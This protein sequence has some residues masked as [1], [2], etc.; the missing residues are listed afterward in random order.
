MQ[1]KPANVRLHF[2]SDALEFP[3]TIYLKLTGACQ[4]SCQ[5]CSQAG[6]A[7]E[8]MDV[9]LAQ[10]ILDELKKLGVVYAYYSGGEPLLHPQI[11]EILSYGQRLGF[12]QLL[13]SNALM[14]NE[15]KYLDILPTVKVLG[16][17]LHGRPETHDA[18]SEKAGTYATVTAAL[19]K[20]KATRP[21][22]PVEI[23]CTITP[24][25]SC[26]DDIKFLAEYCCA[27][28]F[29]LAFARINDIGA[30]KTYK[31]DHLNK[32]LSVISDL[33]EQ[34]YKIKVSNCIAPCIVDDRYVY[35]LHG[36]AA[37]FGIAA[38][39]PNGDVKICPSARYALGNVCNQTF[40]RIWY[41]SELKCFRAMRWLPTFCTSCKH[42]LSCRGGCHAEGDEKFWMGI[43]DQTVI[44]KTE[45][46]WNEIADK[47]YVI[48]AN[49]VRRDNGQY[50]IVAFPARILDK[51]ALSV[52][53]LLDG[54]KTCNQ[55]ITEFQ[56]CRDLL[57]ALKID[58]LLKE[59]Q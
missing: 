26:I 4:L 12:R 23:N 52:I 57:I 48:A 32:A 7:V 21:D 53:K 35:L 42:I 3:I 58:N 59:L 47:K 46:I 55:I 10:K 50:T 44:D 20:I 49:F 30:G 31:D 45:R 36:C 43:C 13:V 29:N 15:E 25:N 40:K 8:Y 14:F 6:M 38:I 5:F 17:S 39:E 9:S 34:G 37:G 18:L 2:S 16:T 51:K 1:Y 54:T 22:L 27:N 28:G 11:K 41:N 19:A 24:S 33:V 56:G